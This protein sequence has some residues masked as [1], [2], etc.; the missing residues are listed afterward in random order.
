VGNAGEN[1]TYAIKPI[2]GNQFHLLVQTV[3]FTLL[4]AQ[5]GVPL[6]FTL[7][8]DGKID[9]YSVVPSFTPSP[10]QFAEYARIYSTPEIGR[11]RRRRQKRLVLH[12]RRGRSEEPSS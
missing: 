4:P 11:I 7:K 10:A 2:N 8:H 1:E 12:R 5:P 9:T 3:D 6:Q